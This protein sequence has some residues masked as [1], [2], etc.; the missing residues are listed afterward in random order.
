MSEDVTLDEFADS[1]QTETGLISDSP[2]G[3]RLVLKEEYPEEWG[4]AELDSVCKV[5]S[6]FTWNKE[7]ETDSSEEGAVPV[8]KIGNVQDGYLDLTDKLYLKG[9]SDEDLDKNKV[10]K[11]W[12]LMIGSNGSGERVGHCGL[13]E[14][15]MEFVYA[16]FLYGL[17]ANAEYLLPRYLF[18]TLNRP[19]VQQRLTSFTAGS[20][21]LKN[22]NK[23]TIENLS[24]PT[25]PLS[26]QRKI[27]TVLHTVDQAIQKTEEIIN[28]IDIAQKGL[29]R[30][31]FGKGG[32]T[33]ETEVETKISR[34]GPKQ[35]K[36][37]VTWDITEISSIGDVVTGDTPST[38]TEGNFDG[39]LPFVTPDT[40]SSGK[41]VATSERSLSKA[42]RE[43]AKP[44]PEGSVMMDCIGSDM[45]KVAI[46]DCEV[47]TN[48]QINSIVIK[49]SE[50]LPEFLYYHL[51]VISDFIKS[52]AGQ[53]ATPIVNKSS[54]R[55][56]EIFHPPI[57]DQRRIVETLSVY[58]DAKQVDEEYSKKLNELKQGLMQDLL[59]GKV[60]T[61][62]ADIDIPKEVA[63]YG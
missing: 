45:G 25:P 43:E 57:E 46:A 3:V 52:Q 35:F 62:D 19:N 12:L 6:G 48:Q 23:S 27:A 16:S 13:I 56:F 18:Y 24:L 44:I 17:R 31:Q 32:I 55:S 39:D 59:S 34:L 9:V 51:R 11:D 54:F 37:P 7:Q 5:N 36:V 1:G 8:I 26:E 49:D 20:T 10:R 14:E 4:F 21:S 2:K 41:Y 22:L 30:N 42:G 15:N 28:Q 58:D 47:A 61:A 33:R 29:L 40:L 60:R 53:T 50:Y 38:D 63:K